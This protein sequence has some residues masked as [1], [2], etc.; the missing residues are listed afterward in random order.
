[1]T[2]GDR[3]VR[4]PLVILR[5]EFDDWAVLYDPDTGR[6]FGLNPT[7][8]YVWKL[9]NGEHSVDDLLKALRRDALEV[10]KE[11]GAHIVAF[12]EEL[13]KHSLAGWEGERVQDYRRRISSCPTCAGTINFN[14][15]SPRLVNLGGKQVAHG[16]CNNGSH[17]TGQCSLGTYP[18][19]KCQ[20]GTH[21]SSASCAGGDWPSA[22]ADCCGGN[23]LTPSPNCSDGSAVSL[24]GCCTNGN[25]GD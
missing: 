20:H 2:N 12:V 10:P 4:S 11:T 9:L 6:G 24:P 17:V 19:A 5:E 15:E 8:V 14:Y 22:A 18:S 23:T 21:A 7:G 25:G 13:I 1:M 3:P 16:L